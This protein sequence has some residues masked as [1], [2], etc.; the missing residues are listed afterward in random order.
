MRIPAIAAAAAC[1]IILVSPGCGGGGKPSVAQQAADAAVRGVDRAKNER[2]HN[3]LEQLRLALDRYAID[4]DGR[5][6]A[7]GS[8]EEATGELVPLYA[9]RLDLEDSWGHVMTYVSDGSSYTVTSPG[10]DGRA[11]T[12]DDLVLHD[13]AITGGT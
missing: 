5:F 6:P 8:L 4:H 1:G 3:R 2:T 9:P 13:G 12:D 10:D 11:G 7:T